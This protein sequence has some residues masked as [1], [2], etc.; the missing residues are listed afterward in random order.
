MFKAGQLELQSTAWVQK[1]TNDR[2]SF[3]ARTR[4]TFSG[5][6]KYQVFALPKGLLF[7]ELRNK[8]GSDGD[9]AKRA[10]MAGAVLGGLVGAAMGA[11][12][13]GAASGPAE[14]EESFEMS[15]EAELLEL[16][17]SRKRS[18]V[19]KFE[20]I[21]TISIDAPG[22]LGRMFADN[23]LA[24]WITLRDSCL[25][26]VKLEIHAQPEMAVAVD[27]LPRRLGNR[28]RVNVEFDEGKMRF[29][30]RKG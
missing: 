26:K 12:L 24:G 30:P 29:V 14:G 4:G 16:A 22:S 2:P 11:A 21:Q 18:F 25:G 28:V 1:N 19:A 13:A 10:I 27:A 23:T 5:P 9:T 6:R 15:G 8:L 7:L 20:E 17:R 3:R